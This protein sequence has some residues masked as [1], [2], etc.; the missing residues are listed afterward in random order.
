MRAVSECGSKQEEWKLKV[1]LSLP[2][3]CTAALGQ[4]KRKRRKRRVM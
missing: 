1:K 4:R 3:G 2:P